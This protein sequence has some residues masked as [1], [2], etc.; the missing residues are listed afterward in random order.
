MMILRLDQQD[1]G[2]AWRLVT[3]WLAQ[4]VLIVDVPGLARR[5]SALPPAAAGVFAH[6]DRL[7]MLAVFA[8]IV[9]LTSPRAAAPALR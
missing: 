3:F 5:V 6:V 8:V 1:R 4:A 2:E 9:S 7:L